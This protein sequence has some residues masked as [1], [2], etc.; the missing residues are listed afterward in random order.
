MHTLISQNIY[1]QINVENVFNNYVFLMTAQIRLPQD[2]RT[3]NT[4]FLAVKEKGK[5]M[6]SALLC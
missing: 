4:R 6:E 1:S 3:T 2:C 5:L